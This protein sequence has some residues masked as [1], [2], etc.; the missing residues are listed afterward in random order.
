LK[1]EQE[2]IDANAWIVAGLKAQGF[3]VEGSELERL[4]RVLSGIAN[5]LSK[6]DALKG[7]ECTST[8]SFRIDEADDDAG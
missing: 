2:T 7:F 8:P 4:A 5:D 1:S 3:D 6:L